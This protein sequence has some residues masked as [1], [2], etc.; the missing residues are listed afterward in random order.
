MP[1]SGVT[2]ADRAA[3]RA[4]IAAG[5]C[6]VWSCTIPAGEGFS[7]WWRCPVGHREEFRYCPA[8]GPEMLGSAILNGSLVKCV[9]GDWMA[10]LVEGLT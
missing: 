5:G 2:D 3:Y 1:K 8:H 9:C 7:V 4:R 10:P 6:Q